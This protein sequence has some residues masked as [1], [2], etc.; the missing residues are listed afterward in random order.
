MRA[1]AFW[2]RDRPGLRACLLAPAGSLYGAMTLARMR[3]EGMRA[4]CPVI[5]IGN[6]V[7]G[8]AGKTPMARLVADRLR[9][10]GRRPAI[11]MRGYG[12]SEAGPLAVDLQKHRTRDVG[13]EAL[14][15]ARGIPVFVARDRHAG[16]RAAHA[17]GADV[18]VLDDGFQNPSLAKDLSLLV[19]DGPTGA[20]NGL[21]LPAGPLRAPLR[22]QLAISDA[23]VVMGD[24]IAG[25]RVA[26][27][28]R[29]AG[30]AVLHAVLAP[31]PDVAARLRERRVVAFAGIGRPEKFRD[32]LQELGAEVVELVA[33][34]DHA[35]PTPAQARHILEA[36]AR[37]EALI[38]MTEKD[39]VKL[40][41]GDPVLSRLAE[42]A[43]AVPVTVKPEAV[44]A[45]DALL[46]RGL[47]RGS[48]PTP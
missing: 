20:G 11:V 5:C 47:S 45:L 17:A 10:L 39:A 15:L 26:A 31:D 36:A 7:A 4:P 28:A 32:T 9:A 40:E 8:G 2:W 21:C 18:V 38:V 24:G 33:L 41:G 30:L 48:G 37:R 13:D 19:I 27:A 16:A 23:V 43:L 1:P 46:K 6:P 3:R 29:E 42:Q 22:A 35:A 34:G 44:D 12:G 25:E 14:L